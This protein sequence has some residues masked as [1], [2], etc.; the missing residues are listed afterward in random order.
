MKALDL[1]DK[2]GANWISLRRAGIQDIWIPDKPIFLD[3]SII[4]RGK[5]QDPDIITYERPEITTETI[6]TL[7]QTDY[8]PKMIIIDSPNRIQRSSTKKIITQIEEDYGYI[9][10]GVTL[11]NNHYQYRRKTFTI[12]TKYFNTPLND[13]NTYLVLFNKDIY[14][15]FAKEIRNSPIPQAKPTPNTQK[16]PDYLDIPLRMPYY[17]LSQQEANKA[18]RRNHHILDASTHCLTPTTPEQ[19]QQTE[20]YQL[21]EDDA[22]QVEGNVNR[23]GLRY[24][25]PFEYAKLQGYIG[26]GFCDDKMGDTYKVKPV[27][28]NELY[29]YFTNTISVQTTETIVKRYVNKLK[30]YDGRLS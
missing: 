8:R 13:E 1:H 3:P 21:I 23:Q 24:P 29:E 25:T 18:L 20:K 27:P 17:F 22:W 14:M 5:K 15:D 4:P 2:C 9:T 12:N 30:E 19:M 6:S 26:Y 7:Q 16:L 10:A 28:P 11:K